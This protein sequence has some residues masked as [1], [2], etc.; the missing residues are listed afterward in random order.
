MT[1]EADFLLL[2][3]TALE[4]FVVPLVAAKGWMPFLATNLVDET[5][6]EGAGAASVEVVV[7]ATL[8]LAAA[9]GKATAASAVRVISTASTTRR[10]VC[11]GLGSSTAHLEPLFMTYQLS[12]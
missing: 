10:Q 11:R 5:Y 3:C 2:W 9:T 1:L 4:P 12:I 7:A 8:L 6:L